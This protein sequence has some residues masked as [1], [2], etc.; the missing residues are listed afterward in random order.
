M[1]RR[2]TTMPSSKNLDHFVPKRNIIY[3]RSRFHL[4]SQG[5]KSVEEFER[6]LYDLAQYCEFTEK[7]HQ[8]RDRFVL[9]LP[10]SEVQRKLHLTAD[11]TLETAVELAKQTKQVKAKMASGATAADE[12][13]GRHQQYGRGRG[14]GRG[15]GCGRGQ[16]QAQ[17][18]S[19][20]KQDYNT[21]TS[22]QTRAQCTR[23]GYKHGTKNCPA[24]GKICLACKG[25]EHFAKMCTKRKVEEVVE[26]DKFWLESVTTI[27]D[28][29]QAW[30]KILNINGSDVRFKIDNDADISLM[31]AATYRSLSNK[32]AL[33]NTS[34]TLT[35][36]AGRLVCKGECTATTKLNGENYRFFIGVVNNDLKNN[37][38]SRSAAEEMDLVKCLDS[39]LGSSG[40]L[41]T[42]PIKMVPVVKKSGKVRISVDFKK[43]NRSVIRPLTMLPNLE[44]IAPRLAGACI[45]STLDATVGFGKYR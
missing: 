26:P 11:L 5:S 42:K 21:S 10:D 1:L 40:L 18:R 36:P 37:F 13:K 27:N 45:F 9:G 25:K 15:R 41:K 43:L 12:V 35:F 23:C 6:N 38:L 24:S 8:I 17:G 7:E 3:E 19:K 20:S 34:M 44:D 39:V 29:K 22:K 16:G 30:M 33:R 31:S 28:D 14:H 4:A 32:P 2:K